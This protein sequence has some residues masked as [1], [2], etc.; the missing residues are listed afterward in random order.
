MTM[1][2]ADLVENIPAGC[3]RISEE[4]RIVDDE[5]DV[6][7]RDDIPLAPVASDPEL[8]VSVLRAASALPVLP[9]RIGH[10]AGL[11]ERNVVEV[12]GFPLGALRAN[13]VISKR[14]NSCNIRYFVYSTK[15]CIVT[16]TTTTHRSSATKAA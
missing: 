15:S 7:D 1:T 13:N 6:Y 8:D 9:W 12:R 10:S 2:F 14:L 3:R 4:I 11:R 5:A 16:S